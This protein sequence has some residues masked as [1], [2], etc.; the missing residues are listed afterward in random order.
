MMA[1]SF[2]RMSPSVPVRSPATAGPRGPVAPPMRASPAR[3]AAG[4]DASRCLHYRSDEAWDEGV[5]RDTLG[6]LAEVTAPAGFPHIVIL[7]GFGNDTSDYTAPFGAEGTGLAH[8]LR[9]RGFRVSVVGLA[10]KDWFGVA[11][12]IFSL[13]YWR[14]TATV[15]PG[16][17][18][19][20][21]KVG[22]AVRDAAAEGAGEVALL[23]HSA[24][25]WL[26][27]AFLGAQREG[28]AGGPAVRVM[29]SL[30]T[31]H[32]APP[33]DSG[34]RDMTGGAVGWV[35][36]RWPGA[37]FEDVSYVSVSGRSVRGGLRDDLSKQ[38]L[39]ALRESGAGEVRGM[40]QY[41]RMRLSK[42]ALG[43]YEQVCGE[44]ASVE[45]DCVVP[46]RSALLEGTRGV[47]LD[48]VFHS[49]SR[50]GGYGEE[51]TVPWYGSA[52]V[53]DAW[54]SVVVDEWAARS[55]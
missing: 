2:V 41:E 11:R 55:D 49:M 17:T 28:G 47:L 33:K 13:A 20:L 26:G 8:E 5:L 30:G 32:S 53:V 38:E 22:E 9:R 15:D 37:A 21:D 36:Q 29:V 46:C 45:G 25:G 24:G 14:G 51:A 6:E 16:Y 54:L 50:V 43:S 18:W 10:R 19:Y 1:T 48:G 31:P 52:R 44:G 42:Y 39:E 3:A 12:A 23:G 4:I 35:S 7:P 40:T 27:R 34:I